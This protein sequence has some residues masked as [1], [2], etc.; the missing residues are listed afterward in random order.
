[1]VQHMR[2]ESRNRTVGDHDVHFNREAIRIG[3][4]AVQ[5]DLGELRSTVDPLG[6]DSA[7]ENRLGLLEM[8]GQKLGL[9]GIHGT[10][11]WIDTKVKIIY[12]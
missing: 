8:D 11:R 3:R 1:M 7:L 10:I 6:H 9:F 5:C 2:I 4:D 12:V